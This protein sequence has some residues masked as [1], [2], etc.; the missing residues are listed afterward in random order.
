MITR[1]AKVRVTN[2]YELPLIVLNI[3]VPEFQE[4]AV[5]H[6]PFDL[7][8]SI[9]LAP[10][11]KKLPL[12]IK[13]MPLKKLHRRLKSTLTNLKKHPYKSKKHLYESKK[14]P[15]PTISPLHF[16]KSWGN[17]DST[18]FFSIKRVSFL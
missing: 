14:C 7:N 18:H 11:L 2:N 12:K 17:S 1:S 13:I 9:L 16:F 6:L 10:H 15:F 5:P 4:G 8:I 3:V